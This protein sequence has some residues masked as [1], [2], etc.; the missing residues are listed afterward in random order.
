MTFTFTPATKEQAKARIALDG[1]S[2]SGKTYTALV[3]ATALGKRIAVIDTERGSAAKYADEFSFDNCILTSFSPDDLTAALAAAASAGYDVVIV[4]SLT[5]FW[6]G[7]DGM[8]EQV[9]RAA[10][11]GYGGN[12]FGGWKEARPMEQ[13]MI[14]ALVSYP[15]HVIV[16][17]RTKTDYVIEEDSRGRK[18]PR[19]LGLKPEQREGIEYEFDVVASMDHENTLVVTKSRCRPVSGAVVPRP[20]EEF[21]QQIAAW[22]QDGT[23]AE[24]VEELITAAMDPLATFDGLRVLM[25]RIRARR[26]QGAAMLDPNG[27]PTTLEEYVQNRGRALRASADKA[28]AAASS[29]PNQVGPQADI[30]Y[31]PTPSGGVYAPGDGP[32][33]IETPTGKV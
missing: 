7:K 30:A 31:A 14:D 5:H 1:P 15:G 19:R 23:A 10:K 12:S 22:L 9:D 4:D 8:R 25:E 3:T 32:D 24:S 11:R 26:A 6:S 2:G 27:N 21:G 18:V 13:R 33:P 16:T 20:T 17:M 28:A 29:I